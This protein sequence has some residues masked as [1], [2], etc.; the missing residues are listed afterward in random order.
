MLQKN[1][2]Y[3]I[4]HVHL[5]LAFEN[6]LLDAVMRLEEFSAHQ[7]LLGAVDDISAYNYSI[8]LKEGWF[9]D[10]PMSIQTLFTSNTKGS[11]PG[12]GA[13]MFMV[14]SEKTG[15]IAKLLA[16]DTLHSKDA[17]V[18]KQQLQEF[19]S[20]NLPADES[21]DCFISGE[22]GDDRLKHFYS[23][24]EALVPESSAI[25]RYKHLTGEY[26]TASAVALRIACSILQTGT[27]PGHFLKTSASSNKLRNILLYNN[28]KGAQHS[29]ILVAAPL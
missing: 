12:E 13:A 15:A 3:N 23:N 7:Y 10:E 14:N 19:I 21:I 20:K 24:C 2:G 17:Q 26:P 16:I 4:T 18:V 8:N 25:L 29:F 1:K 28:F 22:N 11:V 27:I 9:K 6:A 5:G